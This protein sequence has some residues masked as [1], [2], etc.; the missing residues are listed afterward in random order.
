MSLTDLTIGGNTYKSYATVAE[1]DIALAIDPVRGTAWGLLVGEDK[2]KHL[3]AATRRLDVLNWLG[4]KAAGA[5]QVN[6]WPRSGMTYQDGTEV[7]ET[8]IPNDLELATCLLAGSVGQDAA[9]SNVVNQTAPIRKVKAGSVEVE[10]SEAQS[11]SSNSASLNQIADA[12][13]HALI[14]K[15]LQGRNVSAGIASGTD[16]QS[17]FS[18]KN[19]YGY[20]EGY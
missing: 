7:P 11:G 2:E 10:F 15:W 19:Q 12:A 5:S 18:D 1:A 9:A 13:V 6:A 17:C 14:R 20:T 8:A 4:A 3:A 16:G